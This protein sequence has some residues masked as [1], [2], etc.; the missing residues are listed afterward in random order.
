MQTL[1][2]SVVDRE[3]PAGT[4]DPGFT[5]TITGTLAD[6]TPFS[7]ETTG[8]SPTATVS[9]EPGTYIGTVSK[10]GVS[11]Q[12]SAPLTVTGTPTTVTLSVPDESQAAALV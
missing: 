2:A 10:L 3:F 11:S 7:T 6:G 8:S 5:F 1:S 4:V 12:P 9:L